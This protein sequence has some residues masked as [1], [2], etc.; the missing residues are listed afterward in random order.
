[1][2]RIKEKV[3]TKIRMIKEKEPRLGGKMAEMVKR[4][5]KQ[6]SKLKRLNSFA[7]GLVD[8]RVMD[9]WVELDPEVQDAL[10][11]HLNGDTFPTDI[12][13]RLNKVW[14]D[15]ETHCRPSALT[16]LSRHP[17]TTMHVL[18][19][20]LCKPGVLH[21]LRSKW[22]QDAV[23][24]MLE[25]LAER[26]VSVKKY[27]DVLVETDPLE[28]RP[29]ADSGKDYSMLKDAILLGLRVK[30]CDLLRWKANVGRLIEA[31][32]MLEAEEKDFVMGKLITGMKG[33][34]RD[35]ARLLE[36][37]LRNKGS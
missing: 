3:N 35:I 26:P 5:G 16:A 1:M 32:P 7:T 18:E 10:I 15:I 20:Y 34:V 36:E 8:E 13:K 4:W 11:K 27:L 23:Q 22:G 2:S 37:K 30:P 14:P 33:E 31:W 28:F 19:R 12:I 21:K 9:A 29:L 24:V 6:E 25:N 17:K